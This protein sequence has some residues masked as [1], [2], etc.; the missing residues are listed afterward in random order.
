M[1]RLTELVAEK[2]SCAARRAGCARCW[3]FSPVVCTGSRPP[4]ERAAQSLQA[5]Q[6]GMSTRILGGGRQ[7][8]ADYHNAPIPELMTVPCPTDWRRSVPFAA[9]CVSGRG[10][11]GTPA[12]V[13]ARGVPVGG[14]DRG[15]G[16]EM[17]R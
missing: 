6:K 13:L 8:A 11:R 16:E 7:Y 4:R 1:S 15:T 3:N 14:T 5:R 17:S 9:G 2:L 10:A 12:L